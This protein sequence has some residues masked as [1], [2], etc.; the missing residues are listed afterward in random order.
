MFT[1]KQ[2]FHVTSLVALVFFGLVSCGGGSEAQESGVV[3]VDSEADG[4]DET[5]ASGDSQAADA[6]D[7]SADDADL[8]SVQYV[9]LTNPDLP[10]SLRARF[11]TADDAVAA[12]DNCRSVAVSYDE[13]APQTYC[14]PSDAE[15]KFSMALYDVAGEEMLRVTAGRPCT[16]RDIPAGDYEMEICH[17]GG[18]DAGISATI[19]VA[20]RDITLASDAAGNDADDNA[21]DGSSY[22]YGEGLVSGPRFANTTQRLNFLSS[23]TCIRC[24]LT[25]ADFSSTDFTAVAPGYAT[26]TGSDLTGVN[27]SNS[28]LTASLMNKVKL[29]DATLDGATLT[30]VNL[31][32]ASL[33]RASAVGTGFNTVNFTRARLDDADL[34]GATM[35]S[36]NLTRARLNRA[37]LNGANLA[38]A[39]LSYVVLE[40]ADLTGAT[41]TGSINFSYAKAGGADFTGA[42]LSNADIRYTYFNGATM[43]S[44]NFG[45]VNLSRARFNAADLTT[46]DLT[47]ALNPTQA[48][49]KDTIL[50]GATWTDGT[51]CTAGPSVSAYDPSTSKC[52]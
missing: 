32:S 47:G 22:D 44:V 34:T 25:G 42:N 35:T 26:L 4:T 41:L 33:L 48:V 9:T 38:G 8:A 1:L 2:W 10:P 52:N 50:T 21:D 16:T 27:L 11:T 7:A 37:T 19:F 24:D 5:A 51:A 49:W 31:T 28:N 17:P 15:A 39:T 36:V 23:N 12:T 43:T 3:A 6:S 13:T 46:A 45:G 30:S 29:D 14:F 40:S 20:R 18:S